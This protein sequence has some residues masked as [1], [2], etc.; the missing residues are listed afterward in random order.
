M[1][2]NIIFIDSRMYCEVEPVIK[3]LNLSEDEFKE[4]EKMVEDFETTRYPYFYPQMYIYKI[5][6]EKK[7]DVIDW[8]EER[9]DEVIR[10][11]EKR[12]TK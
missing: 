6:P 12:L 10:W 2:Y 3:T 5:E 4:M 9:K 11:K 7:E 8:I 1:L